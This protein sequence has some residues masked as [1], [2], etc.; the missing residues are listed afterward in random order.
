[1]VISGILNTICT[2]GT[3]V[4]FPWLEI[5]STDTCVENKYIEK[6]SQVKTCD[7]CTKVQ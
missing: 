2:K 1:M 3:K 7:K 6:N 4:L 5:A